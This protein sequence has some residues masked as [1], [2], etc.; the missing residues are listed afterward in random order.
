L[1]DA[2][3]IFFQIWTELNFEQFKNPIKELLRIFLEVGKITQTVKK[4]KY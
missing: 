1:P 3:S 2:S 4:R